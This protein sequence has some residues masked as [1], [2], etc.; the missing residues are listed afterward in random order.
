MR[1]KDDRIAESARHRNLT[2]LIGD[3]SVLVEIHQDHDDV[4]A[5]VVG[6]LPPRLER[7]HDRSVEEVTFDCPRTDDLTADVARMEAGVRKYLPTVLAKVQAEIA[8]LQRIADQIRKE[9]A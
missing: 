6:H 3:G 8:D 1:I 7:E 9:L 4:T 2:L 5:V